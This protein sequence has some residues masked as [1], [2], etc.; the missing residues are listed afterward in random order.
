MVA[1][2]A[3]T[4]CGLVRSLNEDCYEADP[5]VGLWLV[6]D[7]V[8]GHAGGEIA[9]ELTRATIKAV[10]RRTGDLRA[11]IE[12][13]HAAVLDAIRRGDGK[14]NMGSTV[15]ALALR[16]CDYQIAWV[17][18]SRAYLWDG[19]LTLLTRD[20]SLVETLLAK[21]IINADEAFNHPQRNIITQSIGV[22]PDHPLQVDSISGVLRPGQRL[23]LCSDGLNDEI[24]E[25]EIA[26]RLAA[27]NSLQEQVASL[28]QG[29][30]T[31]GGRDNVTLIIV[32]PELERG[33]LESAGVA[34]P[35]PGASG[36]AARSRTAPDLD[37][38]TLVAPAA[39]PATDAAP[40]GVRGALE[41]FFSTKKAK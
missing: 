41:R 36:A 16:G 11:A 27:A 8:G 40:R 34:A 32:D 10:F 21:G 28:L 9:S 26:E 22:T 29:S 5:E 1:Y 17:G 4:H 15:V 23:L 31:A 30:L 24:R 14:S 6:A 33:A 37:R 13:A 39:P 19:R 20:H 2:A 38:H 18:D 35:H 3:E 25:R 7:G 12:A